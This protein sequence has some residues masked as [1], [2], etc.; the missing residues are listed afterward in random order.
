M[1]LLG[2]SLRA[3]YHCFGAARDGRR[4][5]PRVRDLPY[6]FDAAAS[7]RDPQSGAHDR[8]RTD[9]LLLTMEMLYRLSYVGAHDRDRPSG[10]RGTDCGARSRVRTG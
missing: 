5:S 4:P 7:F 6:R 1:R 8:N 2:D 3:G 9:D 10:Q